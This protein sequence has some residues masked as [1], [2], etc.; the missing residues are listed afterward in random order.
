M[1]LEI[2]NYKYDKVLSTHLWTFSVL[3]VSRGSF[4]P[5]VKDAAC[6]GIASNRGEFF[7]RCTCLESVLKPTELKTGGGGEAKRRDKS[8]VSL[9]HQQPLKAILPGSRFQKDSPSYWPMLNPCN[10]PF[11]LLSKESQRTRGDKV[12]LIFF[13]RETK[14]R[15]M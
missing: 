4:N 8:C 7:S 5:R 14:R 13:S 6:G 1:E 10:R 11:L 12:S 15:K 3:T 2:K 9:S